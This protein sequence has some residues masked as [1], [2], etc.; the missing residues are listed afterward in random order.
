MNPIYFE[1]NLAHIPWFKAYDDFDEIA[2]VYKTYI[3]NI[4]LFLSIIIIGLTQMS[5]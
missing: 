4:T 3:Y 5:F 2:K 1:L